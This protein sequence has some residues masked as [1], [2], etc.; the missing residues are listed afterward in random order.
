MSTHLHSLAGTQ[1]ASGRD[2][3]TRYWHIGEGRRWAHNA[4]GGDESTRCQCDREVAGGHIMLLVDMR[5]PAVGGTGVC[6]PGTE[7]VGSAL[8]TSINGLPRFYLVTVAV[9]IRGKVDTAE[10]GIGG[11]FELSTVA[12]LDQINPTFPDVVVCRKLK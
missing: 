12:P 10:T 5:A 11:D 1:N 6:K 7:R 9:T 8:L 4:G 3:G 2:G